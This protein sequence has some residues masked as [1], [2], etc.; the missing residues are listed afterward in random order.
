MRGLG[1]LD[2]MSGVSVRASYDGSG[3]VAHSQTLLFSPSL[4]AFAMFSW[5]KVF[6]RGVGACFVDDMVAAAVDADA[7]VVVKCLARPCTR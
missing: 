6:H 1:T 3:E 2:E 5:H 7:V 4:K